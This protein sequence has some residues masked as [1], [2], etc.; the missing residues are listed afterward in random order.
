MSPSFLARMTLFFVTFLSMALFPPANLAFADSFEDLSETAQMYR[1]RGDADKFVD[2]L[3]K[4]REMKPDHPAVWF[5]YGEVYGS[6]GS[7]FDKDQAISSFN[8]FL[9]VAKDEKFKDLRIKVRGYIA[10]LEGGQKLDLFKA[11]AS[12]SGAG[13]VE[14]GSDSLSSWEGSYSCEDQ[15][16]LKKEF[17]ETFGDRL[18]KCCKFSLKAF[19]GELLLEGGFP[20]IHNREVCKGDHGPIFLEEWRWYPLQHVN[21]AVDGNKLLVTGDFPKTGL[22]ENDCGLFSFYKEP[23]KGMF[24]LEG[25]KIKGELAGYDLVCTKSGGGDK[26]GASKGSDTSNMVHFQGNGMDF[27]MDKYEVTQD[28]F[29]QVMRN[30]PS[31]FKGNKNPVEAVTWHEA[32]EYCREVGKR[33]P[34]EQEW[35]YA[36]TSGGRNVEYATASGSLSKSEAN[37]DNKGKSTVP[38]GSYPPNPAGLYDMTGNVW[39]WTSSDYDSSKKV[40][41]GGSW[42]DFN[43]GT[44]R[45]WSKPVTRL[46]I[47]GFRCSR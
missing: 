40:L 44:F 16:I 21:I 46:Y 33:L 5:G 34:T 29:Q 24:T 25:N 26:A 32:T 36:A 6:A 13:G 8:K 47:Y 18:I 22:N 41:R 2:T 39:E 11:S 23:V 27:W 20:G 37:Y 17:N 45:L 1:Q 3:N 19:K 15:T 42:V 10:D 4:M 9:S 31:K 14:S 12:R 38:V 7:N 30:N 43:P 35:Q 28:E